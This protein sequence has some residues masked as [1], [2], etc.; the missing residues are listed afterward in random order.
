MGICFVMLNPACSGSSLTL[1][2]LVYEFFFFEIVNTNK[3]FNLSVLVLVV[4]LFSFFAS[5]II[6]L[7]LRVLQFLILKNLSTYTN[8]LD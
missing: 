1:G 2:I 6:H 3:E 5:R 4:V 7:F 8:L